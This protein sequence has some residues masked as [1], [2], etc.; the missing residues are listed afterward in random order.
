MTMDK[1]EFS[2]MIEMKSLKLAKMKPLTWRW[3]VSGLV[4]F[5]FI[6]GVLGYAIGTVLSYV[7]RIVFS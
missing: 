5:C 1:M 2:T 6:G 7:F 4:T 3:W